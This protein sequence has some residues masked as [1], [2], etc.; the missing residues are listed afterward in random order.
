MINNTFSCNA[1][2]YDNYISSTQINKYTK[3]VIINTIYGYRELIIHL[4]FSQ[5]KLLYIFI[6]DDSIYSAI[7]KNEFN[8]VNIKKK[9]L[10]Q[11]EILKLTISNININ[12][13]IDINIPYSEIYTLTQF[14]K[15]IL[16]SYSS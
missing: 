14:I 10:T 12:Q 1:G 16:N 2:N 15:S 13:S 9:I 4:S 8:I 11:N 7:F 5:I 3:L 6:K